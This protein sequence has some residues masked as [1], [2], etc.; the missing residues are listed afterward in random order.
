MGK[1]VLSL[2]LAHAKTCMLEKGTQKEEKA[3]WGDAAGSLNT[4]GP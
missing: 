4:E 3:G 1:E 2:R